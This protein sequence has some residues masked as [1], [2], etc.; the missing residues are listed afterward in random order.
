MR[1][2]KNAKAAAKGTKGS[3]GNR[4][5]KFMREVRLELSK[6]TWPTRD[7][8]V[9]ATIAVLVAVVVAGVFIFLFDV[10]FSRLIG[11]AS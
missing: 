3:G 6:V 1:S 2:S 7:E 4:V 10:L 8:L 11:L 9:Q 5:M